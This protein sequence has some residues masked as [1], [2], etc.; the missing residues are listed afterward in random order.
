LELGLVHSP[1][2]AVVC[3]L[4]WQA[5]ICPGLGF[6]QVTLMP[7]VLGEKKVVPLLLG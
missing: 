3:S 5:A 1:E 2:A 4:L 6:V 7:C